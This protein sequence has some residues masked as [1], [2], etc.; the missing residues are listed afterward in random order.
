MLN[1]IKN[2]HFKNV[3]MQIRQF[4]KVCVICFRGVQLTGPFVTMIYKMLRGDL[5]RFG[6]IYLI[7]L[8]GFTQGMR[9]HKKHLS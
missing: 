6:I 1:K 3:F 7:F 9:L 8:I 2:K 5:I 4:L